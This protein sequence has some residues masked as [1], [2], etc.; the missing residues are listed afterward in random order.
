MPWLVL[1]LIGA[2]AG[3]LLGSVFFGGLWWTSR[4]LVEHQQVGLVAL[5][6]LARMALL[7]AG[8]IG[9]SQLHPAALVGALPGLIVARIG[10]TRAKRPTA[11]SAP[12]ALAGAEAERHG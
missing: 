1:T 9:L 5:S 10:W 4:R 12:A 2:V 7:T 3:V 8:L 6:F 11:E